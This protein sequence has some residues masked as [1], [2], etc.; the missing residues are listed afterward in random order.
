M[1]SL[2]STDVVLCEI[3]WVFPENRASSHCH[4]A[5][6]WID[7]L[8]ELRILQIYLRRRVS[9]RSKDQRVDPWP[10]IFALNVI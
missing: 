1:V 5:I 2:A 6:L 3:L 7:L 4:P 9:E 10:K 8:A